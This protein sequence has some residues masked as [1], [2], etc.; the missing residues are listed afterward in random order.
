MT[1]SDPGRRP[2]TGEVTEHDLPGIGRRY[3]VRAT[4]GAH[5]TVVIH[6]SGRRDLY[7]FEDADD[8]AR[9]VLTL[10]DSQARALGAILGG[11]YFKP[12]VVEEIEA[13]IGGLLVDWVTLD[14]ASPATGRTIADLSIRTATRM[15]VAAV[16]RDEETVVAP[17]PEEQLRDG[18][19]LVVI[20]RPEDL[21]TFR[22]HVVRA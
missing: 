9:A 22:R 13:V 10:T 8:Q 15:T 4:D 21:P 20:G 3:D 17:E 16:V 2:P 5:V 14:A 1:T 7:A 19:R 12:A 6:H 11:A 18:D